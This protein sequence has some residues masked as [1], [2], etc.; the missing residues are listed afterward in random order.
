MSTIIYDV[1]VTCCQLDISF[2]RLTAIASEAF[3]N[4][5]RMER[6]KLNNNELDRV[7]IVVRNMS[8]LELLDLS[9]NRLSYLDAAFTTELDRLYARR[10][11]RMDIRRNTFICDCSTLSFVRWVQETPVRLTGRHQVNCSYDR[12]VVTMLSFDMRHLEDKCRA[13]S[14]DGDVFSV[15]IPSVVAVVFLGVVVGLV[16]Q[17]RW[18]LQYAFIVCRL[19]GR[20]RPA[21]EEGISYDAVVLYFM[22]ATTTAEAAASRAVSRWIAD[23]LRPRAEDDWRL[24]LHIGDRD[25]IAGPS[26]V[27]PISL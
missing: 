21:E 12:R 23:E 22:H 11:F 3:S 1:T 25:D 13:S 4:C 20:R 5:G 9:G 18:Y 16:I 19:K 10:R 17:N 2:N 14:G 6:L 27:I 7:D 24:R 26:K 8:S 15:V